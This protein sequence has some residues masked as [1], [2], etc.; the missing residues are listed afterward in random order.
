MPT[1]M[2]LKDLMLIE[3]D[4]VVVL[5][6]RDIDRGE[7]EK[8]KEFMKLLSEREWTVRYREERAVVNDV[9]DLRWED[10]VYMY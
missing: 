5:F 1:G 9:E 3:I 4:G 6:Y 10:V 7:N 2:W 8:F